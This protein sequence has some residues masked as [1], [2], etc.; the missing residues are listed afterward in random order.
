MAAVFADEATVAAAVA[1]AGGRVSIA[2]LNG[3]QNTVV[4]GPAAEVTAL[5][6]AL[7]AAGVKS[8]PLTTSHAFHSALMEPALRRVRAGRRRRRLLAP[9][10]ASA[11][12]RPDR[13]ARRRRRRPT[14]RTG[15]GTSAT[16]CS[17]AD[18]MTTL[19]DNGCNVFLE[20]GPSPVLTAMGQRCVTDTHAGWLASLQPPARRA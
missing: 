13:P 10:G 15:P 5:V 8:R 14:R 18:G 6:A 16:R 20:I 4:S 19:A 3:P 7:A 2:A 17:F 9:R 11:G 12:V 1:R